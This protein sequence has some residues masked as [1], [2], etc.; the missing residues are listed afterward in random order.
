MLLFPRVFCYDRNHQEIRETATARDAGTE[1]KA[2]TAGIWT[3]ALHAAACP[4]LVPCLSRSCSDAAPVHCVQWL[5]VVGVWGW[6]RATSA[7]PKLSNACR[8]SVSP[9]TDGGGA[10][11]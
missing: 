3:L 8:L 5:T 2:D 4:V 10:V 1:E 6:A 11:R 9:C 7:G